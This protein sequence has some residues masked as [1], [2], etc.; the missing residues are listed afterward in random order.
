M[1]T[2]TTINA[3]TSYRVDFTL[4][5]RMKSGGFVQIIF[6][7]TIVIDPTATC[8]VNIANYS[9]CAINSNNITININGTVLPLTAF[10]V[11]VTKVKN[12]A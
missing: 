1:A 6:P 3:V 8:S 5:N 9:S 12:A 11:A 10:S 4:T 7:A 2:D